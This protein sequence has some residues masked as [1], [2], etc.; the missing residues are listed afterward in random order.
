MRNCSYSIEMSGDR[1]LLEQL[2]RFVLPSYNNLSAAREVCRAMDVLFDTAISS[3]II[4][5]R[6][7][8]NTQVYS[9]SAVKR[10]YAS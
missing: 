10:D 4:V 7:A 2:R 9:L 8:R 6:T 5:H 1:V 3:K